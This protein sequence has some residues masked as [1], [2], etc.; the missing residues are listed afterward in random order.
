MGTGRRSER[1]A[2]IRSID[3]TSQEL[4]NQTAFVCRAYPTFSYYLYNPEAATG[5]ADRLAVLVHGSERGPERYR[6]A[7]K[8]FARA[9]RTALLAPLFP[10]GL[11]D[12]D[13]MENYGYLSHGGI[14]YDLVLLAMVEEMRQ[15]VRIRDDAF[16]LH[17]FSSG[18]QFAHRFFYL[19]PER[20]LGVSVGAPGRIT[21]LDDSLAW[22]RGVMDV[23][24]VFGRRIE[25]GRL[26]S[27]PVQIVV[28]DR[29]TETLREGGREKTRLDD[30]RALFEDYASRGMKARL[31]IVPGAG[32]NGMR[33]AGAV[34]DFFGR[35][36]SGADN[37]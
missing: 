19:H 9:S 17:G 24:Q 10:A 8:Q 4:R 33:L 1:L 21:R 12:A 14:R 11:P 36:I 22:P 31:D 27:V 6:D 15:R 26:K 25:R 34:A 18:G 5:D 20:L 13:T 23:E 35:V 30:N 37:G 3:E 28:G 7:F 16:L 29:D 2:R 32:H